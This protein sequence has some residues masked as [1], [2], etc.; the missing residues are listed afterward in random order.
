LFKFAAHLV[1]LLHKYISGALSQLIVTIFADPAM[2]PMTV[3]CLP[4]TPLPENVK[5]KIN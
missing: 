4:M 5:Q 2:R 3:T 1:Y